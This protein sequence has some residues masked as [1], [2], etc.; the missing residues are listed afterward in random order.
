MTTQSVAEV[1]KDVKGYEG[2]YRISSH[3]RVWSVKRKDAL[4]RTVGGKYLRQHFSSVKYPMLALRDGKETK[5]FQTHKLVAENFLGPCPEGFIVHH[6]NS[7]KE[8]NRVENLEY[9]SRSENSQRAYDDGSNSY[10]G[11]KH[12]FSKLNEFQVRVIRRLTGDLGYVETSRVFGLSHM[13]VANIRKGI[14]WKHVTHPDYAGML[15]R[16]EALRFGHESTE[17]AGTLQEDL[18]NTRNLITSLSEKHGITFDD[19]LD[20]LCTA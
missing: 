14:S 4:G 15:A 20:L 18:A 8:D 19:F 10:R 13:T 5:Y 11:T 12:G 7:N 1:W 9:V 2:R 6:K 3:G 16:N 17:E